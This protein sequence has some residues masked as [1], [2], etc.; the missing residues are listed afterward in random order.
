MRNDSVR[1]DRLGLR[2]LCLS[3]HLRC[4]LDAPLAGVELDLPHAEVRVPRPQA[5]LDDGH[6]LLP[7]SVGEPTRP[8]DLRLTHVALLIAAGEDPYV[9]SQRRG[10]ASIRTTYDIYGHLLEGRDRQAADALEAAGRD[11]L[12]TLRGLRAE[13][14]GPRAVSPMRAEKR[15][16]G[17]QQWT[18]QPTSCGKLGV[19]E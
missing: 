14:T 4:E 16:S 10:H 8:H 1:S 15:R 12:R 2:L 11:L 5:F 7:D 9:I 18:T 3:G 6:L 19:V 17:A 13:P